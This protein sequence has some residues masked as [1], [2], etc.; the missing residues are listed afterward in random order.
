VLG[1]VEREKE[2]TRW[3]KEK[4]RSVS[5]SSLPS[6]P[7]SLPV[8]DIRGEKLTLGQSNFSTFFSPTIS[9]SWWRMGEESSRK[10]SETR[11]VFASVEGSQKRRMWCLISRGRIGRGA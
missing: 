6:P 4:R 10:A 2:G 1:A 11:E 9:M 7:Q 3:K 8:F 5:S